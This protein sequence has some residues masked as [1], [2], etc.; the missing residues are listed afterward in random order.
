MDFGVTRETFGA[1]SPLLVLV[2][3]GILVLLAG[4]FASLSSRALAA[5]TLVVQGGAVISV[6]FYAPRFYGDYLRG[7][8]LL[9][10]Y[11]C[12]GALL[13]LAV[14]AA[15]TVLSVRTVEDLSMKAEY[16]SLLLFAAAGGTAMLWTRDL[17]IIFLGLE[18]LTI[19][20]FILAGYFRADRASTEGSLKF[21]L[22]GA[23]AAALLL[24]GIALL[25]GATG[26]TR[27]P[28][29]AKL[30]PAAQSPQWL[31]LWLGGTFVVV[32][33][34][35]KMAVVPFH[36][37]SPDVYQGAPTPVAGF[38]SVGSKAAAAL[39]L[40]RFLTETFPEGDRWHTPL[41]I[42]AVA[43]MLYGNLCAIPQMQLKRMLAYSS[44]AHAGYLLVGILALGELTREAVLVYTVAYGFMNLGAF[45][46]VLAFERVQP[47]GIRDASLE[48]LRGAG[49]RAPF[50]GAVLALFMFSLAGIPPTVGF[51]AKYY[52]FAAALKEGFVGLVVLA[53]VATAVSLYFYLR[54]V[55]YLYMHEPEGGEEAPSLAPGL[56]VTLGVCALGTLAF[57]VFPSR[58]LEWAAWAVWG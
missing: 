44:I 43:T 37:W 6:L 5:L 58:L 26:S 12:F 21:F 34:L 4:A 25:F 23:F 50:L 33:L 52:L 2:G 46:A 51:V 18:T 39:V 41:W 24:Y 7:A 3:G 1:L 20:S 40:L 10:P 42:L 30:L 36:A 27:I 29:I 35:F 38:L 11:G 55:V 53:V 19:A 22:N 56:A 15:T 49:Y 31:L 14:A 47:G 57:G 9:D 32:G 16:F 45:A 13:L 28:E 8:F 54:V 17:L 48:N